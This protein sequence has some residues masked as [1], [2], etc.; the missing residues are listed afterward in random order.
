[1][2]ENGQ[3]NEAINE[4]NVVLTNGKPDEKFLLAEEMFQFGFLAEAKALVES[5]LEIYPEEGELLVLLGEI[6]VE[7]GDEEQAILDIRKNFGTRPQLWTI[8]IVI[9]RFISS[10]RSL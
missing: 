2:L 10:S 6:L 7:A 5:L 4:Y 3:H 1:M 8:F 9:S